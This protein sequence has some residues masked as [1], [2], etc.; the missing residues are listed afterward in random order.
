MTSAARRAR[1]SRKCR[2]HEKC[3]TPPN[4]DGDC[5][6][7]DASK[8]FYAVALRHQR[9]QTIVRRKENMAGS[10]FQRDREALRA[11]ARS[12]TAT[13]TVSRGQKLSA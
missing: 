6:F 10:R 4:P 11:D 8:L 7:I 3:A 1:R 5:R 12:M 2:G 9:Q 13:K